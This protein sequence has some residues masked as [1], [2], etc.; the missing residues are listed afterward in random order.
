[1]H[2]S[3]LRNDLNNVCS[4]TAVPSRFTVRKLEISLDSPEANERDPQM[5]SVLIMNHLTFVA[6][7]EAVTRGE[8][9][10]VDLCLEATSM[11]QNF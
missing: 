11:I 1:M 5:N 7:I 4:F 8:A 9:G 3:I 6:T 10:L 2:I